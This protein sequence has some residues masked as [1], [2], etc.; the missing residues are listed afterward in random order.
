MHLRALELINNSYDDDQSILHN[1][2]RSAE[3]SLLKSNRNK[4]MDLFRVSG[5]P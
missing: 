1:R 4:R 2:V 3:E 5:I